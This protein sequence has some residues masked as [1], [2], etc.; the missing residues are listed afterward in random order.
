M[1]IHLAPEEI[2][3]IGGF[4]VTN[5]LFLSFLTI[6]FFAL[7]SK[8]ISS[9]LKNVPGKSQNFFETFIE[10][11]LSFMT[12][13][14]ESEEK[15]RKFFPLVSTIFIFVIF[16]NWLEVLPGVGSVF[17]RSPSSDLNFTLAIAISSVLGI[18]IFGIVS[19]G[20]FK[21][22]KKFIN[23]SSPIN[24]FVGILEIVSEAAKIISFS[25]RLFGNIFAGEV[26]LLVMY[27]LVP[28][29]APLPFLFLEL[30]VG[31]VQALV[32]SMLT[33]VFL[34]I[35]TMENEH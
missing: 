2:F 11:V 35:A 20:F 25:F 12:G 21:Y 4:D 7:I 5:T 34:K 24:F 27:F 30:F 32:F 1:K 6:L 29:F 33:L 10:T 22:F 28:Y 26:L 19:I 15:A 17:L 18:Q 8:L 23:F 9:N 31:F 14:L 16:S 13:I 3:R